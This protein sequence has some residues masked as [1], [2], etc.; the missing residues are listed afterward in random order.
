MRVATKFRGAVLLATLCLL[1]LP[2]CSGSTGATTTTTTADTTTAA[3]TTTAVT[4]T[5]VPPTT[6]TI[7]P[8]VMPTFPD[9]GDP[10]AFDPDATVGRLDNGLAYYIRENDAP[11]G[12]AQLRLVVRAGSAYE[13]EEQAGI[14]HFLEH[15]LFNGT[16]SYPA[17]ELSA[18]LERFG[19]EFGPDINAYTSY[20]ETVY[21]LEL[22]TDDPD[23]IETGFDVLFEWATAATLDPDEIDL[24]RGVLIEEWRVRDQ[25]FYGRYDAAVTDLLLEDTPYAGRHPLGNPDEVDAVT[26]A[27]LEDFYAAWY[28]PD[29]MAIVAV[30]DFDAAQIE[31]LIADR[32]GGVAAPPDPREE[33]GLFTV[34]FTSPKILVLAD[35]EAPYSFVELNYPVPA[36]EAQGTVGSLR[37][38]LALQAAFAMLSTRLYEDTLRGLT[39]FFDPSGAANEFVRTQGTDGLWAYANP[40]DLGATAEALLTAVEQAR[41]FGFN[42]GELDRV[43]SDLRAWVLSEY[44]EYGSKQDWA[45][46]ADYVEHFVGGT[47]AAEARE[48]RDLRLRLIDELTVEQVGATFAAT[49]ESTEPLVI[50]GGPEASGASIP[51]EED[52]LAIDAAVVGAALQARPDD[53]SEVEALMEEPDPAGVVDESVLPETVVPILEYENG[54]RFSY[55]PT[56]IHE[57]YVELLAASPG[58][59]ATLDVEDVAEAKLVGDL[60]LASGV[61]GFDQVT[62][63]RFLV[64]TDV[65]VEPF[66]NEVDEGF[67]GYAATEDLETLFQLVHLYMAE[68]RFDPASVELVQKRLRQQVEAPETLVDTAFQLEIADARFG[69]DPRYSPLPSPEELASLDLDRA[70]AVFADRFDDPGDF[71]FVLVGDFDPLMA[72]MYAAEYLGTIAGT[73]D[74]EEY[75]GTRPA[76]PH[77]VVTRIVQAGTGER[78]AV[79]MLFSTLQD[80]DAEYRVH[81]DILEA[82]IDL[83]LTTHIREE[84]S[85]SYSPWVSFELVDE[86]EEGVEVTLRVDGDPA[87]LDVVVAALLADLTDLTTN[88][89]SADE[90]AIA[91]E[92]VLRRY[93]LFD[94]HG[95]ATAILFSAYYPGESLMELF[96]RY[97]RAAAATAYDIGEAARDVITLD[98]Y[99]VV[100][101]VPIGFDG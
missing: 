89:P 67:T 31:G 63:D 90:F 87:T 66:I 2:A 64:G 28:R 33:P 37:R 57:G 96:T 32:F 54:L 39:P 58:G 9:D 27:Q 100:K 95:F 59:W 92:Q 98:A 65:G 101:L 81:L 62:L 40:T 7:P 71:I 25:G 24:E 68:P 13:T 79:T 30:G 6:T 36:G 85:A 84:L 15:M 52:L 93:E 16:A 82:V 38:E 18:V 11:G 46:A 75:T 80:L 1:A 51:T 43:I 5:T 41:R 60:I 21:Q 70:A 56:E 73:H 74:R 99:V 47:P 23:I 88:G 42:Q 83:R 53:Y 97:D 48:W 72:E 14:A 61:A 49:I 94:D 3:P 17:N 4:T 44:E 29:L 86:P 55:W 69:G 19:A 91:R 20:E 12:R 50:V 34:P 76:A 10:I 8:A 78:G 26:R 35:P 45:F 22:A 77:E